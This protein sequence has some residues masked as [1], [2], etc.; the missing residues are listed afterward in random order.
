MVATS[1]LQTQPPH[2]HANPINA[3]RLQSGNRHQ[4]YLRSMASQTGQKYI[5][6]CKRESRTVY[7]RREMHNTHEI[8][9]SDSQEV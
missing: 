5:A 6:K 7:N 3:A 4:P 1:Q 9:V 2:L 8:S